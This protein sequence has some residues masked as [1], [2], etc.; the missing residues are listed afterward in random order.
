MKLKQAVL[1]TVMGLLPVGAFAQSSNLQFSVPPPTAPPPAVPE[2]GKLSYAIG[3]YFGNNITNSVKRG[4][5]E[6]D[7]N[8]VIKAIT[9]VLNARPT[10]LTQKEMTDVLA[11]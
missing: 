6:V 1:L 5:L 11:Q 7:T 2:K 3:M 4:E 9:D 10:E 8:A